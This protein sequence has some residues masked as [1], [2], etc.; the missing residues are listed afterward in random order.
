MTTLLKFNL[1]KSMIPKYS[2]EV[3]RDMN[4]I[5]KKSNMG[6]HLHIISSSPP[7]YTAYFEVSKYHKIISV[8]LKKKSPLVGRQYAQIIVLKRH[9]NN[10]RNM[11]HPDQQMETTRF[12]AGDGP[13]MVYNH[14]SVFLN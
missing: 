8:Q 10:S 1:L 5:H 6:Y 11:Y 13:H 12:C 4:F 7:L 14:R 2:M 9:Y 3:C